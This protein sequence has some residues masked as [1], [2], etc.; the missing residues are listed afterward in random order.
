MNLTKKLIYWNRLHALLICVVGGI[1]FFIE[2]K[3][4]LSIT[5]FFSFLIYAILHRDLL[6]SYTPFA[7]YANWVTSLRLLAVLSFPF[8][9]TVLDYTSFFLMTLLVIAG[10]GLDGYLARKYKSTSEFGAYLDM[11]TDAFYVCMLSL[12]LYKEGLV[13]SWILGI[14]WLRY[15]AVLLEVVLG[16]H[17]KPSAPNPYARSIAAFLF[18][19]LLLPWIFSYT[20]YI[21]PLSLAA[22]L[23]CF[24]FAYSF[25]LA[26]AKGEK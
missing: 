26:L 24:S 21:I 13:A 4:L 15:A 25:Y 8:L 12:L 2:S 14:G 23:V 18:V 16:I 10:D 6:K 9:I 1:S 3:Y 19:A 17:G 20:I 11:E 5:V 22:I 7:G